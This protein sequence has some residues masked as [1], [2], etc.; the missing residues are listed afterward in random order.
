MVRNEEQAMDLEEAQRSIA[1]HRD[2]A[3]DGKWL[4]TLTRDL[5]PHL[6]EWQIEQAWTWAQ[7]P[8]RVKIFGKDSRPDDDGIDLVARRKDGGLVAIQC[9]ARGLTAEGREGTVTG[10]DVKDFIIATDNPVWAERWMVTTAPPSDHVRQKLGALADPGKRIK[11]VIISEAVGRE[12]ER[13]KQERRKQERRKQEA[14]QASDPRTAMQDKAIEATLNTLESLRGEKHKGWEEDESRGKTI[15]PCGTGKT[16]VGYEVSQRMAQDELTVIM[17]PSIGLVRQLRFA[18]L[19]R[20]E[21]SGEQLDPLCVCSDRDVARDS[22]MKRSE[23]EARA[24]ADPRGYDDP[25][26]D[27]GLIS[28]SEVV[29]EVEGDSEGIQ[30]WLEGAEKRP[31]RSVIFSTYQ[32]GHQTAKALRDSNK[33]A[34]LLICD[35]AHRTAGIRKVKGKKLGEKIRSFTICHRSKEFPAR[36]RLYMT[37]TPRIYSREEAKKKHPDYEVFTMDD[38]ATFG[39]E[40]YRLSYRDAVQEGYISDYRIIAR[41]GAGQRARFGGQKRRRYPRRHHQHEH[42]ETGLRNGYWGYGP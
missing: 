34:A 39:A 20:A 36:T 28:A 1:E 26:E 9:K 18:W 19:D 24:S 37:A 6:L 27:W 7:W 35:E 31:G 2:D 10:G 33:R 13:R 32:S 12:Q 42:Q 38:E 23:E 17:A 40:C 8:D 3:G 14:E 4:E 25:T 21:R 5:A 29:G 30:R 41:D 15:M 22:A 11:W 16:R